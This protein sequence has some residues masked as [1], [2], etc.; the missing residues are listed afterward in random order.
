MGAPSPSTTVVRPLFCQT[1]RRGR[2][3]AAIT[4]VSGRKRS[5][6]ADLTQP[7]PSTRSRTASRS[8]PASGCPISTAAAR[9]TSGAARAETPCSSTW[10]TRSP[11]A[12]SSR[13]TPR[14][15]VEASAR[16]RPPVASTATTASASTPPAPP[17]ARRRSSPRAGT[18]GG[19]LRE[20]PAEREG[21]RGAAGARPFTAGTTRPPRATA[22]GRRKSCRCAAP[23]PGRA[24][25]A[26][27][28][29]GC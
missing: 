12:A 8:R 4:N 18:A 13:S 1:A 16:P 17:T 22:P 23:V 20:P 15:K 6:R 2:S 14:P 19:R 28:P 9:S 25:W 11:A 26:S 27:C 7:T 3:A 24:K 5:T 10:R 29:V 21:V